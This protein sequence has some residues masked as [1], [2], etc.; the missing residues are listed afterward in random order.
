LLQADK[1]ARLRAAF[2]EHVG[3]EWLIFVGRSPYEKSK[4]RMRRTEKVA[5]KNGSLSRRG[6][7]VYEEVALICKTL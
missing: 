4:A 7:V 2:N 6:V 5:L 3:Q 1:E